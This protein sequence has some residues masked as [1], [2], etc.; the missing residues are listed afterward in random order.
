[1]DQQM[2]VT[3]SLD[4][5]LIAAGEQLT[6]LLD[7]AMMVVRASFWLFIPE[8]G[9]WRL[10]IATPEAETSGPRRVYQRIQAVLFKNDS[11]VGAIKLQDI[12]V[13]GPHDPT[14]V[15]LSRVMGTDKGISG[16]RISRN[17]IDGHYIEDAYIYRLIR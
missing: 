15:A 17:T 13:V 8:T 11:K 7:K 2:Y 16:I 5:T 4:Q 10:V 14:V 12:S 6:T 1:M 3:E 9:T